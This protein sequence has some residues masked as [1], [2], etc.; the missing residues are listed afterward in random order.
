MQG[1]GGGAAQIYQVQVTAGAVV[2]AG[3]EAGAVVLAPPAAEGA[4]VLPPVPIVPEPGTSRRSLL[5][6]ALQAGMKKEYCPSLRLEAISSNAIQ[7]QP[8]RLLP[9]NPAAAFTSGLASH[10][11]VSQSLHLPVHSPAPL[12]DMGRSQ[13]ATE[14]PQ[15]F[16]NNASRWPPTSSSANTVYACPDTSP[17]AAEGSPFVPLGP[18]ATCREGRSQE[19][20]SKQSGMQATSGHLGEG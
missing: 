13:P 5:R 17:C 14:L 6:I 11:T 20:D 18:P 2:A 3:I 4:V 9:S 15:G 10:V 19:G 8:S 12:G 7:K 1:S 16:R